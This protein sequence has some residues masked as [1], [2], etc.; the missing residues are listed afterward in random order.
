MTSEEQINDI[1]SDFFWEV[2]GNKTEEVN[3]L[4]EMLKEIS[5]LDDKEKLIAKTTDCEIQMSDNFE[6]INGILR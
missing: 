4:S 2:V 5:Y 3:N 6:I 1:L